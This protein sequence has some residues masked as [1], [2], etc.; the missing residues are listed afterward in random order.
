MAYAGCRTIQIG[1]EHGSEDIRKLLGKPCTD[2]TIIKSTTIIRNSGMEA[3]W[4]LISAIPDETKADRLKTRQ[5]V[6]KANPTDVLVSPLSIYPGTALFNMFSKK[7]KL[8]DDFWF[9]SK[10]DWVLALPQEEA[11]AIAEK[12]N[13]AIGHM[14]KNSGLS[15]KEIM[16]AL[17]RI[18]KI[19]GPSGKLWPLIWAFNLALANEGQIEKAK[20]NLREW[21]KEH[22]NQSNYWLDEL[23]N[24]LLNSD[25][26]VNDD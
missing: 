22:L 7:K 24:E 5:L 6:K 3:S 8:N 16:S 15:S 2:E 17:L 10:N 4:Y 25:G 1:V 12:E 14:T 23:E 11:L 20:T 9:N 21:K 19:N 18:T 13:I 26:M